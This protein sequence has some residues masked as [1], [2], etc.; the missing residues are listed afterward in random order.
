MW[1]VSACA[2]RRLGCRVRIPRLND[3]KH[4]EIRQH[5]Q[6]PKAH[7]YLGPKS[8]LQAVLIGADPEDVI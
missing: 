1:A 8:D 6:P 3:R 5:R 7:S 4:I 2:V